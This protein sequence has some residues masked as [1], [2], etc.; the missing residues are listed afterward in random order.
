MVGGQSNAVSTFSTAPEVLL[1]SQTLSSP[2]PASSR[3]P[4]LA[5]PSVFTSFAVFA[6]MLLVTHAF[7]ALVDGMERAQII[8][9]GMESIVFILVV[10]LVARV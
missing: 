9:Q 6:P 4:A 1:A 10:A 7:L 8:V 5:F 2:I 3:I